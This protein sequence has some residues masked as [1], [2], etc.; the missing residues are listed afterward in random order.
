[1][2]LYSKRGVLRVDIVLAVQLAEVS[3]IDDTPMGD[4]PVGTRMEVELVPCGDHIGPS[5]VE[6]KKDNLIKSEPEENLS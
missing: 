2:L 1:M 3:R 4:T 6:E 5:L